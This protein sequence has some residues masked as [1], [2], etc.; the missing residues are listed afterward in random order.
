I[1]TIDDLTVE[2]LWARNRLFDKQACEDYYLLVISNPKATVETV[3]AK[4]KSKWRPTP[5]DTV[6]QTGHSVW[7]SFAQRVVEWGPNPRNGNKSDQAHPP[8]HPTKMVPN[9]EG[10]EGRVYEL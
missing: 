2:F 5:M 1:H 8:I 10:N 3:T 4:P 6:E 9:L 7:G